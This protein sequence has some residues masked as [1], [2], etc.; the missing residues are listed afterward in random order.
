MGSL[1]RHRAS[2]AAFHPFRAQ[3][4]VATMRK[5]SCN[6]TIRRAELH[7][8]HSG[9]AV[10]FHLLRKH[11]WT[12]RA[13]RK[14]REHSCISSVQKAQPIP[15]IQKAQF[16]FIFFVPQA[17]ARLQGQRCC[18]LDVHVTVAESLAASEASMTAHS[19]M[20]EGI[21]VTEGEYAG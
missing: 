14:L 16:H 17:H 1:Q 20:I 5:H 9:R 15:C 21:V 8:M 4:C 2:T 3:G 11:S 18:L 6:P 12:L 10:D 7:S 13:Q 19:N